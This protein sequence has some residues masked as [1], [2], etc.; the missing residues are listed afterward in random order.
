VWY[1]DGIDNTIQ[2]LEEALED[3]DGEYYYS[4]SW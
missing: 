2:I 1:F 4:S 3:E